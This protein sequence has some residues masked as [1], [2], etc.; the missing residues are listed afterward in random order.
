MKEKKE[1]KKSKRRT[2][3]KKRSFWR[4]HPLF[5]YFILII[6]FIAALNIALFLPLG[7]IDILY[8]I[9]QAIIRFFL[10]PIPLHRIELFIIIII[11]LIVGYFVFPILWIP[12]TE[13]WFIYRS[14]WSDGKLRYF[15]IPFKKNYK[16]MPLRIA[17][18]EDWAFKKGLKWICLGEV[19]SR[20]ENEE[21]NV[22]AYQSKDI[23]VTK[24][25]WEIEHKKALEERILT[26]E[27]YIKKGGFFIS[28]EA[29]EIFLEQ[30]AA[31]RREIK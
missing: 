14:T 29:A 18:P 8:T 12:S 4:D 16:G 2:S 28:P 19:E 3:V 27:D 24:A 1:K 10:L 17:L 13:E 11:A 7:I 31:I 9:E 23:E 30:L 6:I 15:Q 5:T 20:E 22:I 25:L 21:E 26:L